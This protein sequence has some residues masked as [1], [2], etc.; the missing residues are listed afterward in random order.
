MNALEPLRH[1]FPLTAQATPAG[2]LAVGGCD[3]ADLA[4]R[5]GTPLYIFD[6][7]TLRHQCRSFRT[8]FQ[9]AYPN[10]LV[11]YACKAYITPLLARLFQEE[12][13]GLDVVS[14]GELA[15]ARAVEFPPDTIYF[16]GNNKTPQELREAL[17]YR[18]GRIVVD[19]FQ[20]LALLERLAAERG[21]VQ[22]IL[23]RITP[24]VDPHTHTHTTTGVVDSKFGFPL[25]DG[26][27]REAVRRAR[28]SPHL[29]L[30][31]L[32][33]HLGSPIFEVEPYVQA[34]AIAVDFAVQSGAPLEEFSPGGGF[35]I[36]YTRQ[37]RPPTPAD[38]A[39]AIAAALREACARHALPL[40]R[41][42][43]EPGRAI[44]GPS[45][46]ALYRVG[47][48]KVIPGVRT[49]VAVDGGMGDNIRPAL[50]GAVYEAVAATKLFQTP[51]TPVTIAGK[52]CESGDI[53]ARDVL[54]PRLEPGDL[55]A[56]P[57]AGAYAPAMASTYNLNG[58]PAMVL[59]RNGTARLM[60]RRE[61][62]Q[63]MMSLD[64]FP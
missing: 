6:E 29:A 47:V 60:R 19:N 1:I 56:M 62:P 25:V 17:D 24:G 26:Q 61:T 31:G 55:I 13:L 63:D 39:R 10:S 16:H 14:G 2:H 54:L 27:A 59:V 43:V 49:Y 50:Y 52:Y 28:A 9:E 32:H 34:I 41:L 53:L 37:Q 30:K 48:V 11:I 20:E 46:V 3:V 33:F 38:Y 15:V 58:R 57:C 64:I 7:E 40:P 12:G 4:E 42:V 23:L 8:A 36:A 44:V 51:D 5:F 18:I 21:R 22:P 35:A 45:A